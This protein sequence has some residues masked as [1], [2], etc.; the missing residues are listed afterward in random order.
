MLDDSWALWI[1]IVHTVGDMTPAATASGAGTR[2]AREANAKL[3]SGSNGKYTEFEE[4]HEYQD[5]IPRFG[6]TVR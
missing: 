5:S 6:A 1:Q 3:K 2:P 4:V